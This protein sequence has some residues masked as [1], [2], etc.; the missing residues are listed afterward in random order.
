MLIQ[1]GKPGLVLPPARGYT[2]HQCPV[3]LVTTDPQHSQG[4]PVPAVVMWN[5]YEWPT[6]A[7]LAAQVKLHLALSPWVWGSRI[8]AGWLSSPTP[9]CCPADCHRASPAQLAPKGQSL[10]NGTATEG[11]EGGTCAYAL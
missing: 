7:R 2:T 1:K 8:L 9:C 4:A 10:G 6:T 3:S 11:K 5:S